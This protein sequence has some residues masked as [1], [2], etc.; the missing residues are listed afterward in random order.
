MRITHCLEVT[1]RFVSINIHAD[2][3]CC[4]HGPTST[5]YLRVENDGVTLAVKFC[6]KDGDVH[7]EINYNFQ[8]VVEYNT[9]GWVNPGHLRGVTNIGYNLDKEEGV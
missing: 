3:I 2:Y 6:D 8:Q 7:K 9:L 5:Q 1:V 4:T